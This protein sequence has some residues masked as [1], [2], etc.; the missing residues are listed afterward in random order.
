MFSAG[1]SSTLSH[2]AGGRV[3]D[4][5]AEREP[6]WRHSAQTGAGVAATGHDQPGWGNLVQR[7]ANLSRLDDGVPVRMDEVMRLSGCMDGG[8]GRR[9]GK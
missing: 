8:I 1:S 6:L 2:R 5:L 3:P 7:A 9:M 4:L